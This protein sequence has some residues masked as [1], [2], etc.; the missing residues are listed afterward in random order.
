MEAAVTEATDREDLAEKA[1]EFL[2]GVLERMGIT[3]DID[4]KDDSATMARGVAPGLTLLLG[5]CD[6]FPLAAPGTAA[7]GG[8]LV[9]AG[10][11]AR[12]EPVGPLAG[13][14]MWRVGRRSKSRS[15][16]DV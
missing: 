6:R 10:V 3:A 13:L 8:H 14:V 7:D 1:S 16:C 15:G 11:L 9:P 4:I 2:L 12:T 5:D